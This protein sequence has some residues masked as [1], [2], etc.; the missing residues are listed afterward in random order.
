MRMKL[1]LSLA[2]V[3][4]LLF[5]LVT[6]DTS[7]AKKKGTYKYSVAQCDREFNSC[8]GWCNRNR[9]GSEKQQCQN[10]CIDYYARCMGAR[11][12]GTV[13]PGVTDPNNRPPV[14]RSPN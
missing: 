2:T 12:K 10:N 8:Y 9:T 1:S 11:Y 3:L 14:E 13:P 6:S 4:I 7:D 5:A